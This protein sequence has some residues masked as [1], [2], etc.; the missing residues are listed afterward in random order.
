MKS[1]MLKRVALAAV[2]SVATIGTASAA[3]SKSLAYP[4]GELTDANAIIDQVYYVN[5][6][7]GFKNYAITRKGRKDITVLLSKSAGSAPT[8]NTLERYLNND[9]NDGV[10]NAQ[11]LAIFR[12]GKLKGTG[13]L[14]TDYVEEGKSQSYMIWLPALRKI[15]RFAQPGHDESWAVQTSPSAMLYC[16]SQKTKP[17]SFSVKKPLVAA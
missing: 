16:V 8:T 9:Y 2:M 11:D 17:T 7:Y 14:I 5:H 4:S 15:R 6:F 3:V 1:L 10:T 12:S 13:M